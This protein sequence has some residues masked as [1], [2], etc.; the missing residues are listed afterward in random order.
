MAGKI[1]IKLDE[2]HQ[3]AVGSEL[4][5]QEL[6]EAYV[7]LTAHIATKLNQKEDIIKMANTAAYDAL[8]LIKEKI[9]GLE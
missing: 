1:L 5:G 2:K 7:G 8:K 3:V 4:N 6:Y 9:N